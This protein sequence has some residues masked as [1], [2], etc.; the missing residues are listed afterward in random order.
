VE[1]VFDPVCHMAVAPDGAVG[2]IQH[3]S[4]TYYFCSLA[5]LN[6]FSESPEAFV[7]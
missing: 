4:N 3:G 6:S 1:K 2:F 7:N 5:C